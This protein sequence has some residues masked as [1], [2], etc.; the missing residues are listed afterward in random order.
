MPEIEQIGEEFAT[1]TLDEINRAFYLEIDEF[2]QNV[3][4]Q[5]EKIK[6]LIES[7]IINMEIYQ[8]QVKLLP[9][10][11]LSTTVQKLQ[12]KK[13]LIYKDFFELQNL[14]NLFIY[15]KK[16]SKKN[17][18]FFNFWYNIIMVVI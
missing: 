11:T 6:I 13:D 14:I 10:K 5:F 3:G 18:S 9:E 8:N 4:I 2:S 12:L 16:Q 1:I 17:G 7:L 15:Q